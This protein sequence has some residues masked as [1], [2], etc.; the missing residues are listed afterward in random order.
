M[1]GVASPLIKVPVGSRAY[2]LG[3][4]LAGAGGVAL[5]AS[6]ESAPPATDAGHRVVE[7]DGETRRVVRL[8]SGGQ[9][10]ATP[11]EATTNSDSAG[12][13]GTVSIDV[14][15]FHEIRESVAQSEENTQCAQNAARQ[16]SSDVARPTTTGSARRSKSARLARLDEL[17]R[18]E[19]EAEAADKAKSE[20]PSPVAG[21]H[22]E[23]EALSK[24]IREIKS[25]DDYDEDSAL[26]AELKALRSRLRKLKPEASSVTA[27]SS[28]S[29]IDKPEEAKSDTV[30]ESAR[31]NAN[32]LALKEAGNTAFKDKD[33]GTAISKYTEALRLREKGTSDEEHVLL[34]NR[35]LCFCK[36]RFYRE[37]ERDARRIVE[38]KPRWAKGYYRLASAMLEGINENALVPGDIIKVVDKGLALDG[39]NKSL[40]SLRKKVVKLEI[41]TDK[42]AMKRSAKEDEQASSTLRNST[43]AFSG[44]VLERGI[45][46]ASEGLARGVKNRTSI[47]ASRKDVPKAPEKPMSAFMRRRLG[48]EDPEEQEVRPKRAVSRPYF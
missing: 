35:S 3:R 47:P 36:A 19:A 43:A 30:S 48:L 27:K 33:Y 37:A 16:P 10:H 24:R 15:G 14:D 34:S 6:G 40:R 28:K 21:H 42:K 2:F 8:R 29:N 41:K 1:S 13:R 22:G 45:A 38:I 39:K 32:I 20:H 26:M 18:L 23:I 9:E 4:R 11:A 12:S 17:I 31:V 7:L 25:V 44:R 46:S 5:R